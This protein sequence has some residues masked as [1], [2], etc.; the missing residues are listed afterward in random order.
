MAVI[1]TG[2]ALAPDASANRTKRQY[3]T[4]QQAYWRVGQLD[5]VLSKA[6]RKGE[7]GQRK[8]KLLTIGFIGGQGRAQTGIAKTGWNLVDPSGLAQP[9]TTY[10]FFNQGYSNCKVYKARNPG[11][12]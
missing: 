10:H 4:S 7:F 9:K 11:P 6:C 5:P 1:L 2:L 3:A 12:R 8:L